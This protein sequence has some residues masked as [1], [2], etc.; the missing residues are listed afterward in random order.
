M[1]GYEAFAPFYDELTENVGYEERGEYLLSLL[2]SNGV[3]KGILLDLACGTG[4][5]SVYFAKRG[6]EVIGVDISADMLSRARVKAYESGVDILLLNQSMTQLDLY[7]TV[8]CAVCTLD[9][10]NHLTNEADVKKCFEC[11]S[12]FMNEGG[13][14]IFDANT[15]Y[16]HR[17]ILANNTFVYDTHGV[18]CVWQ[19]SFD[20]QT[21]EVEI[22]LDFFTQSENGLYE[23]F[24]ESFSE[25]AYSDGSL[26]K[27]LSDSG[28]EVA[29]VY[30]DMTKNPPCGNS[31]RE[32]FVA[33]KM[34]KREK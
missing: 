14:F 26:I 15:P 4:S 21:D 33:R 13:V 9:S 24:E 7:G 28:F 11:V 2:K 31:Q 27:M 19:N 12:L 22:S 30:D 1:S 29:A 16:K 10:I 17:K 34:K 3:H 23:R 8:D 5:L 18:Y 6:Y 25:C 32:I 20:P